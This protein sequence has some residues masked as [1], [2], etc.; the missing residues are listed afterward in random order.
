MPP[1]WLKQVIRIYAM[2]IIY[3][4]ILTVESGK[5]KYIMLVSESFIW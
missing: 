4:I 3:A 1:S 2:P 5:N